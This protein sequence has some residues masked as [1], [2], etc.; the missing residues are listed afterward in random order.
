MKVP[1]W[2]SNNDLRSIARELAAKIRNFQLEAEETENKARMRLFRKEITQAQFNDLSDAAAQQMRSNSTRQ[3][4]SD[5]IAIDAELRHRLSPGALNTI[6][7]AGPIIDPNISFAS[8]LPG[9]FSEMAMN[10]L[11]SELEQMADKL[12]PDEH[13]WW[14][15]PSIITGTAMVSICLF[16]AVSAGYRIM[17]IMKPPQTPEPQNPSTPSAAST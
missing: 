6:V 3:L 10:I 13:H 17:R 9:Q 8:L 14:I 11:A 15:W 16:W 7:K 5:A 1:S 4:R 2:N 12:P